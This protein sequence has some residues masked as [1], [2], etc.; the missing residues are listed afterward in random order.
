[1]ARTASFPFFVHMYEM[2]DSGWK[3][4]ETRW[5]KNILLF[6]GILYTVMLFQAWDWRTGPEENGK[7]E[8]ETV[9]GLEE[10][11]PKIA[12]TF[13]DGPHPQFTPQLLD[14]LKK[15]GVK[16]SFFVIGNLAEASPEILRRQKKEGHL[17]GNH[18]YHH[19]DIT[20]LSDEKARDEIQR[21]NETVER[22]TGEELSFVRPPFG[23]W[24]KDLEKE[25]SVIPVL[26]SVDPLDWTTKNV[27]E[28]VNKVVTQVKENDIILL[29]DCYQSSVDAALRIVD[30]LLKEG[31]EFVTVD[32]M[33]LD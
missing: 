11:K 5:R 8:V 18:T 16:A 23:I 20:K 14:G 30:I 29:H 31:Y 21:T 25:L 33:I 1:M 9:G 27:D 3:V 19:V 7:K 26:W 10:L 4:F 13:D 15:R 2:R 32:E 17:I 6:C 12:I 28:I 22:I 24:Q